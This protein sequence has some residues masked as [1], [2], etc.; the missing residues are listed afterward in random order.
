[1][2]PGELS[3]L[4]CS[5]LKARSDLMTRLNAAHSLDRRSPRPR[6]PCR[7]LSTLL[8]L[9]SISLSPLA[10]SLS[11]FTL[12]DPPFPLSCMS[13]T[14]TTNTPCLWISP[15]T[16]HVYPLHARLSYMPR[17]PSFPPLNFL[18]PSTSSDFDPRGHS[19][20]QRALAL[21]TQPTCLARSPSLPPSPAFRST[22][23]APITCSISDNPTRAL[24]KESPGPKRHRSSGLVN[25][26]GLSSASHA[27]GRG[28][29][30]APSA[31]EGDLQKQ[32][33]EPGVEPGSPARQSGMTGGH[34]SRWTTQER[35]V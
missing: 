26:E 1:M 33:L 23:P 34:L 6:A 2:S 35:A 7:H 5:V 12:H 3:F 25:R 9:L 31:R 11:P 21:T 16:L 20:D 14:S 15:L 18:P 17:P 19:V 8:A 10:L 13:P 28:R 27:S 4:A 24:E 30:T 29:G 22:D 32:A